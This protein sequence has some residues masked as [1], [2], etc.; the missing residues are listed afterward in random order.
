[1]AIE[2]ANAILILEFINAE[3]FP[4]QIRSSLP[5][6]K[7]Y[8]NWLGI[9]GRWIRFG[10]NS[11]H[12][13]QHGKDAVTLNDAELASLR[14]CVE[15]MAQTPPDLVVTTHQLGVEARGLLESL[16]PDAEVVL[17]DELEWTRRWPKG[18]LPMEMDRPGFAPDYGWESGNL[19]AQRRDRNNVYVLGSVGCGYRKSVHSNPYY[20]ALDLPES[21]MGVC[22]FCGAR[23]IPG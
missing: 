14:G 18:P 1:M 19:A 22:A 5:L 23:I 10:L 13:Y 21:L 2:S 9:Q 8:A 7:G 6:L 4:G 20:A 17:L 11:A 3:Q 16:I 15:T 12:F